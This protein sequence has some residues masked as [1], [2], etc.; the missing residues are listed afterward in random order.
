MRVAEVRSPQWRWDGWPT[1]WPVAVGADDQG[2]RVVALGWTFTGRVVIASGRGH[3]YPP[4]EDD[5]GCCALDDK[6]GSGHDGPCGWWC[7][8]CAGS[9]TCL[10]CQ[11]FG[12]NISGCPWCYGDGVCPGG[13]DDGW[14]YQ[15]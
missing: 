8:S 14:E 5:F 1:L 2:R 11:G 10:E 4:G 6:E 9:G 15:Q 12:D 13:C 3:T 7:E